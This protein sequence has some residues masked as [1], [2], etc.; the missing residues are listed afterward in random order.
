M[1]SLYKIL[2]AAFLK[3]RPVFIIGL[4]L[5]SVSTYSQNKTV[6]GVV[7]DNETNEPIPA[8]AVKFVEKERYTITDNEGVF[9]F[10]VEPGYKQAA[11]EVTHLAYKDNILKVNLTGTGKDNI[12]VYMISRTIETNPVLITDYQSYSRLGDLKELSDVLKGKE[13]QRDLGL[14]LA[15][16]LKNETGI[17]IRSMG[18]A[19]A[20]PVIRGLG[21]DRVI[22]TEDGA[23]TIDLSATSPDHAVTIDPF[24][25]NRIEVLRGPKVLLKT[26]TTIGG[27]VNVLRNEIPETKDNHILGT[28]GA[29]GETANNGF[30]GSGV[31]EIPV[32]KFSLRGEISKRRAFDLSTPVGK[33]Q[34]SYSDNVNYSLGGSYFMEPGYIGA[35]VRKFELDY[36]VPGGFLGAHPNGVDI[37]MFRRQFNIKSKINIES[38]TFNMLDISYSYV[39]YRH[40]E[41]EANGALGSEFRIASN[42]GYINL[43]HSALGLFDNGILG[44]SFEHRDFDIG[45]FVFTPPTNSFNSAVYLYEDFS[46]DKFNFELGARYNFDS[47]D[48]ERKFYDENIGEVRK[49]TFHTY[50][51]SFSFLYSL[52][53]VVHFGANI[54][55]SSRVPTIEELFSRGPHLAAY[56]YEVGNTN[57]EDERGWGA[58]IFIYNKF[59]NFFFNL[60][61]FR[62]DLSYYIIPRNTGET[63]FQTLLPVYKTYGVH[64]L[65][66]GFEGQVNW[67]LTNNFTFGITASYTNG[68]FKN[69]GN[70]L[71]QI[72]PLK[73]NIELSYNTDAWSVGINSELAA[74]Q[75]KVD[76][77]EEPTA[78]YAVLNGYFQYGFS[79]NGLLH[80]IAFNID[81]ILNKEYRNH[82]SRVKSILP[83]AGINFRLTYKLYFHI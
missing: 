53:S 26:S 77:F 62:N 45:G 65:F 29:Y 14:T 37:S 34:N 8:A 72:P 18:P 82:L 63:N 55:K 25:L 3:S 22:I 31:V 79:T 1:E 20:R 49:R 15:S 30:L 81:N 44:I 4:F 16:T 51:L 76:E 71:P 73:G 64:A 78:G 58:E 2:S 69:S 10:E 67:E 32:S 68:K 6:A 66:Y 27:I 38:R 42:L 33:L 35:S 56:S 61:A 70:P 39:L 75:N 13:L 48:P 43:I 19:P 17:A 21:S 28:I 5:L 80:S 50:S 60:N 7:V 24:N 74:E 36:G 47:I 83:E 59:D 57:L 54:N 9:T 11:F 23:K 41:F 52:S 40:K 12:V 46:E